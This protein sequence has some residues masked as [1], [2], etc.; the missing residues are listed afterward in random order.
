MRCT[1][2]SKVWVLSCFTLI[3]VEAA[4]GAEGT[5]T[6]P[7][8]TGRPDRQPFTGHPGWID[9]YQPGDSTGVSARIG[10]DGTFELEPPDRPVSLIASFD[11]MEIPPVIVPAW[12]IEPG[13]F[14]VPIEP[15]YCCAPPGYPER[16]DEAFKQRSQNFWQTFI[17][18]CTQL[19]G[20]SVFDGPKIV[21]WGNKI[22]VSVHEGAANTEPILLPAGA[23]DSV[24]AGHSDKE[25][26]R[27]GWRHGDMPV[28]SGKKYCIRIGG[29]R[30]HGGAQFNLDAY[31]RPDEGDGYAPGEA[32]NHRTRTGGDLCFLLFGNGNGQLIENHIRTEEWEIFIP[33]RRPA[34]NWGQTFVSHGRS[35]AG[36]SF[37]G[38]NGSDKPVS[39]RIA[40]REGGPSGKPIGPV[41]T[42]IG[43]ASPDRPIIRYPDI[44]GELPE[45]E[46]YYKL[47]CDF[48]QV[49]Y[50]PDEVSLEPGQTYYV[51]INADDPLM[52]YADGDYYRHGFAYYEGLKVEEL[53]QYHAFHSDRWTLA[54]TIVTYENPGGA[55][56]D[57][58]RTALRP[59]PGPDGNL[60]VNGGAET[61]DFSWWNVGGDPI[62]DPSTH[63]PE[64]ANH[65]GAH[66]FGISI[67][68]NKAD[69]YQYQE[70]PNV[71]PG[72][73]YVAGMWASHGDGTDESCQLLWC[74]GPFGGD[75][76]LLAETDEAAHADWRHYRSDPFTPRRS[77][78]T[79]IVRYRHTKPTNVASIHV[80]DLYL[81]AVD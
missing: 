74:D 9:V 25:L 58:S 37:W 15:E 28:V 71:E 10:P 43:H 48:F 72:K 7:Y 69:F 31:V 20:C 49:A 53:R 79:L 24:S 51:E 42:A 32:L 19:Y 66:R 5:V 52:L 6:L 46:S 13:T 4:A 1:T 62:I 40:I 35:L 11:K 57:H 27:I 47:P 17:P 33:R 45:H 29:Y 73:T 70:V 59:K 56:T 26:P 21:W 64:P 75:E 16:W 68:W 76:Q 50:A 2:A 3:S 30:P 14:D 23:G 78:V 81:K 39:C 61:G 38:S 65:S 80:D 8:I 41:K 63:I 44:P 34:G 67:G 18:R 22:N 54:M 60:I 77:T 36:V 55:P 12:P